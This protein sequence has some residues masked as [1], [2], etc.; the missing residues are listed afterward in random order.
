MK[1]CACLSCRVVSNNN[2]KLGCYSSFII[3]M[4]INLTTVFAKCKHK[5]IGQRTRRKFNSPVSKNIFLKQPAYHL[6]MNSSSLNKNSLSSSCAPVIK[7]PRNFNTYIFLTFFSVLFYANCRRISC[8]NLHFS[9]G[10][11]LEHEDRLISPRPL[12]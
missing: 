7:H 11:P 1:T 6:R 4:A 8:D 2:R 5:L 12:Q 10:Q 9:C 3:D